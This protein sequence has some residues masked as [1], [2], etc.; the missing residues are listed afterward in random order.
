MILLIVI[1]LLIVPQAFGQSQDAT[2]ALHN[3]ESIITE[4]KDAG[5]SV[6]LPSDIVLEMRQLTSEK[7]SLTSPDYSDV[8]E[9]EK[10]IEKI[11]DIA[12]EARDQQTSFQKKLAEVGGANVTEAKAIFEEANKEFY[13]E[14]YE[15]AIVLIDRAH[16]KLS[17]Y[18]S[19]STRLKALYE[20]ASVGISTLIADNLPYIVVFAIVCGLAGPAAWR[21][22]R[23][24]T[25][26]SDIENLKIERGILEGLVKGI[27]SE[28]FEKM[29]LPENTYYL[30]L[31]KFTEMIRDIDSRLPLK[32]EELERA[33]K[34]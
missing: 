24:N 31:R 33:L 12:L 32:K 23:I 15:K 20:S 3:A 25:L 19:A 28:Y 29:T 2:Q 27:Q 18:Q 21:K 8:I 1:M 5:F 7:R 10:R 26:S 6:S 14:R 11:R 13:D 17:E 9:R 22:L 30:R 4:M 34:R 16:E